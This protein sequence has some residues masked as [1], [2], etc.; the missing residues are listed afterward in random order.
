MTETEPKRR[1]PLQARLEALVRHPLQFR[2]AIAVAL[3]VAWY[4]AYY[5]PTV[6]AIEA[7]RARLEIERKRLGLAEQIEDLRGQAARFRDRIPALTD[8]NAALQY[9]LDAVRAYP[10]KLTSLEPKPPKE[11]GPYKTLVVDITVEGAYGDLERLLRW[12]E[13]NPERLFRVDLIRLER[14]RLQ[15]PGVPRY[16]MQLVITGVFS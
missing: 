12:V 9:L 14:A 4:L 8:Q 1:S 2:V 3:I 16:Q 15:G 5:Q 7:T 10:L 11:V 13:T 6:A